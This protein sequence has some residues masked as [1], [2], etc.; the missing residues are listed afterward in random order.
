MYEEFCK[1]SDR[2]YK[3]VKKIKTMDKI[4]EEKNYEDSKKIKEINEM[5]DDDKISTEEAG[6]MQGYEEV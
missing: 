3:K 6:F 1:I 2:K 5:V 4:E